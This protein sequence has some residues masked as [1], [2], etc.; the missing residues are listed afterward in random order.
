MGWDC[1]PVHLFIYILRVQGIVIA[2][3]LQVEC[4]KKRG[5]KDHTKD[6]G[7]SNEKDGS[8]GGEDVRGV[9]FSEKDKELNFLCLRFEIDK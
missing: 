8:Q 4:E 7:L 5:V 3:K 1:R 9:C 6:F 2:N